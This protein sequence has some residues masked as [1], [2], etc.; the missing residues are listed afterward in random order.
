MAGSPVRRAKRCVEDAALALTQGREDD[1]RRALAELRR[2]LDESGVEL[3]EMPREIGE[4]WVQITEPKPP[5]LPQVSGTTRMSDKA[6]KTLL[7]AGEVAA[8]RLLETISDDRLFGYAGLLSPDQQLSWINVALQRGY[9]SMAAGAQKVALPRDSSPGQ[10]AIGS[11][12]QLLVRAKQA[13]RDDDL[14]PDDEGGEEIEGE[15]A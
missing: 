9:G 4:L 11:T 2:T 13:A 15:V 3:P 7:A 6:R 1:A 14:E 12:L 10:Q 5:R 8:G